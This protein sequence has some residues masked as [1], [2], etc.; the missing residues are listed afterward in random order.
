MTLGCNDLMGLIR[1]SQRPRPGFAI[2][3][4]GLRAGRSV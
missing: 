1:V 2:N 4:P 3:T